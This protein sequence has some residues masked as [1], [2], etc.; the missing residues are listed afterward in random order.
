MSSK[1]DIRSNDG[2]AVRPKYLQMAQK[3]EAAEGLKLNRD[4]E[5]QLVSTTG[6]APHAI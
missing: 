6:L 4:L 2:S 5:S 3:G 1:A